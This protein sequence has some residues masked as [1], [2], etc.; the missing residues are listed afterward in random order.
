MTNLSDKEVA[1]LWAEHF[2]KRNDDV[3]SQ[4]LILV[5]ALM[6]ENRARRTSPDGAWPD[7]INDACVA[8]GIPKAE[9]RSGCHRKA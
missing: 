5:F 4:T 2:P 6:V 9:T 1:T 7:R 8:L 3:K